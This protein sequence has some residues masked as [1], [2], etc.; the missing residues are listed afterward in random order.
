MKAFRWLF[1]AAATL[2]SCQLN[3]Q[4]RLGF[5][6]DTF[7]Q[8][9]PLYDTSAIY[10]NIYIKNY[11]NAVFNDTVRLQYL[12][13]DTLHSG[14]LLNAG[15]Y[16]KPDTAYLQPGD[17]VL[18]QLLIQFNL[19][20]FEAIGSSVVVIWPIATLAPAY[21]SL[22]YRVQVLA[23]LEAGVNTV[24][25]GNL[26]VFDEQQQ[27]V[28]NTSAGNFLRY[29]RVYDL[30][31]KLIINQSIVSSTIIPMDKY[32]TGCYLVEVTLYDNSRKVFKV[33]NA[34]TH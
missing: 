29:I 21:D 6:I 2:V 33:I 4:A 11:G 16:L 13:N 7:P 3:A 23:T 31:G 10:R 12:L 5:I 18:K 34:G 1:C 26:Q 17:S 24:S 25:N 30:Q 28:I 22:T 32:A 27:L 8:Q 14:S 15:L 19:P 9:V 20:S